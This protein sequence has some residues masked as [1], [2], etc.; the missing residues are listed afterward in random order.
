ML[1]DLAQANQDSR[2][3]FFMAK[4]LIS[5]CTAKMYARMIFFPIQTTN[6]DIGHGDLN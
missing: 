4:P 2:G 1:S 3:S 6:D 5:F